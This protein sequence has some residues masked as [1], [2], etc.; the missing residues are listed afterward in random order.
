MEKDLR[1][2]AASLAEVDLSALEE[3]LQQV[4]KRIGRKEIL[5]VVKANAYGH[6]AVPIARLLEKKEHS[7]G[8]S[9]FGV[10]YLREGIEL[11]KAGI[12]LPIL[13]MTG[14]PAEQIPE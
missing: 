8:I 11:R 6:G 3:N 1:R 4:K 2:G 5:A 9:I 10:A 14:C 7:H 13:L 12:T